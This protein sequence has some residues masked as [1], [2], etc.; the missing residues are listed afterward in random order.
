[1]ATA[2]QKIFR[3]RRDY[4]AWVADESIE[5]YALRYTP[6]SFRK[7]SEWRV[8]NT[9]FGAVSFLV[10]EAIGGTM[11][12]NYGFSNALWAILVVGLITFCTGLPISYYAARYGVDMDLLTRGAGFGYLGS[13]ITSLIYASFT[14]IFFALE[15]AIMAL[16]LQMYLHIPIIWCYAISALLIVPLVIRGITLIS[17]LQMLTQG[18]WGLLLLLPYLA[19]FWK[20]PQAYFDFT[21]FVGRTSQSSDFNP[22]MF[23]AAATVA[24]SLVV[25]IGEQVDFLRFLPE[26]TQANRKRWWAAVLIAGPG[27]IV[28]GM[29]KMLGGAFLAFLALQHGLSTSEAVEPTQMYLAGFS[30]VFSN[31]AWVLAIT[32]VFVVV[33]QVKINL[34]NAY[35]GSL[36]WSNFFARLT[37][38]HPGRVVWLVFNVAIALLLMT[39]GVFSALEKVL[40][41]YGNL[42]IA[43]VGA[44]VA[45]LVINKPLG[46]SP[47]GIE[48][49][50]AHLYDINPV[51]LGSMLFAA[52]LAVVA[53][54]GA[55]GVQAQAF[56]PFIALGTALLLSPLLAWLTRGRYYMARAPQTIGAPG[57]MVKCHVCE[58]TFEAEDMASCPAYGAPICSLCCTLES[59]CHDRCKTGSRAAEQAEQLLGFLLPQ[60]LS[61]RINFRAGHYL[62]VALSLCALLATVMGMVYLQETALPSLTDPSAMLQSAFI[63]VFAMLLLI[64]AVCSWW[65]VLGSESRF[66]A[67]DESNRQNQLLSRE[68]EAHQ[69][70][71]EA[72]QSAKELAE[73]A[74]QAKTRYV[75]GVTHEL[76]T[77]LNSILGYSQILLKS[78]ALA[79]PSR[80]AVQ[81]IQRSGEHLLALVDGLLDLA[82]IEAGRLRLEPVALPL[83][84]FL[85]GL[86]RMMRPQAQAK[87][88]LFIYTHSGRMPAWVQADAK[89][90]RQIIINLL[91]NAV[92]FTDQGSVTL[93]VDCRSDVIRFDVIDTG[94]GIAAQD[95]QR[96][97]M[98]FERGAAGRRRGVPGT[99]LGLTIT[100]LLTSLMGGD[101][102]LHSEQDQ[103]STFSVRLY[104]REIDDPGPQT[105]PLHQIEGFF[106]QR[107]TLLVVDD[108]PVQRQMLAGMLTPIGF[109]V[110]E[111]AS[112]LECLDSLTHD[113][114]DAILLDISMDDMDGWQTAVQ[115][116]KRGYD[117]VPIIM[118]SAN[119]FENQADLLKTAGC[120]A[121]V[122]KPVLESELMDA[123]QRQ[124]GLDWVTAGVMPNAPLREADAADEIRELPEEP[125]A[126]LIRLVRLGHVHGLHRM[127]DRIAAQD[128]LL[129]ASCKMLR[130]FVSRCELESMLDYLTEEEDAQEP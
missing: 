28:P 116:R 60:A 55:L 18:L 39:L 29:L 89:R 127:L 82:R 35:A 90:L 42:A 11:A 102:S 47:P 66:M 16:A 115:I 4:N 21:G 27:W 117:K 114:P 124:L 17:K 112:G 56:S 95:Q 23:G 40:G 92:R 6:R 108:Q 54:T 30:Y 99:G 72:L 105:D 77:P 3:I 75:A 113:M 78:E 12:L 120:Q 125:R 14:F 122:G 130:G 100:A 76:R 107:R 109:R 1:M 34:T 128:P 2:P 103:G 96:I 94:I 73:S 71:D 43:W 83:P 37:H 81:T 62:V 69:R 44:L 126:E 53:Y 31:P 110:T 38:S 93:H 19:V 97:F 123:L 70:T 79:N 26:K 111:A 63:K 64:V 7:W 106:G 87:D 51:G 121:F 129:G 98:P 59:R 5:D 68:I 118:V 80:E 88:V 74:N 25:Q 48:F 91:S 15:A 58:N 41:L 20:N 45:D 104:L 86:V 101:L 119:V 50:R 32:V 33:S 8:G 65:I 36:A 85:E 46:L 61:S 13:T 9:A 57:Q 84:D 67:Q 24:F 49:K 10:L 52:V 22:L